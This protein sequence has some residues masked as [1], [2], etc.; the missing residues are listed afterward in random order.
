M[1]PLIEGFFSNIKKFHTRLPNWKFLG[2]VLVFG[3][4]YGLQIEYQ[5]DLTKPN[6]HN[7]DVTL[8]N[9]NVHYFLY[10]VFFLKKKPSLKLRQKSNLQYF[11]NR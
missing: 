6:L 3:A 9:N 10:R 11:F 8:S 7:L 5:S 1:L 2:F 4:F